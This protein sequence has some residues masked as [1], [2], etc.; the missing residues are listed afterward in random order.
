M[1]FDLYMMLTT[2][3]GSTWLC[4]ASSLLVIFPSSLQEARNYPKSLL[5]SNLMSC[6]L[7]E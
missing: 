6:V 5:R 4:D 1:Y 7:K 2:S 3:F